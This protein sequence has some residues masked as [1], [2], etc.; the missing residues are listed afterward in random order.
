MVSQ[1]RYRCACY[2]TARHASAPA[3]HATQSVS[4]SLAVY[5]PAA[6]STHVADE[7]APV[8]FEY[9]PAGHPAQVDAPVVSK[10]VKEIFINECAHLL[11]FDN[12]V[13]DIGGNDH[14]G[15]ESV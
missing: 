3:A 13:T 15:H 12:K 4:A 11:S 5:L 10:I 9:V 2:R 6:Q 7:L 8:A 14:K 1:W